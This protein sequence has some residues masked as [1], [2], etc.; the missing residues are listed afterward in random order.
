MGCPVR[1]QVQRSA[2]D[3]S[4]LVTTYEG[5]HNHPLPPAAMTMASTTTAAASMLLSGSIPSADA[6]SAHH[7]MPPYSQNLA[8][9]SAS[10]PFPTVTLDLTNIGQSH[11]LNPQQFG[12]PNSGSVVGSSQEILSAIAADPNFNAALAAA[13]GSIIGNAR[14]NINGVEGHSSSPP[15][16]IRDLSL[17]M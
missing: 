6:G 11:S 4:V 1:K 7:L 9:I 5:R 13:I 14:Q 3:R 16:N 12:L 15:K 10:A 2:D 8:T 17:G